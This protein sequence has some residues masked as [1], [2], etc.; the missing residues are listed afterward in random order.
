MYTQCKDKDEDGKHGQSECMLITVK[1]VDHVSPFPSL[2]Y[3]FFLRLLHI[4][5][6]RNST[7]VGSFTETSQACLGF[8]CKSGRTVRTRSSSSLVPNKAAEMKSL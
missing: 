4:F 6:C 2:I 7:W 1:L 5:W 3:L 8:F